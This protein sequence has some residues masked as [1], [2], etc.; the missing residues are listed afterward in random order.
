[1]I[2]DT[3]EHKNYLTCKRE[4]SSIA[5]SIKHRAMKLQVFEPGDKVFA[6]WQ[7]DTEFEL[8]RL[9]FCDSHFPHWICRSFGGKKFDYWRIPQIHLSHKD[10]ASA[11]G[12]HNRK[13]LS[14]V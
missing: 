10:I 5:K 8:I 2:F 9:D 3:D 13:Q 4:S 12:E 6:R 14:L 1:M 7:G 11:I